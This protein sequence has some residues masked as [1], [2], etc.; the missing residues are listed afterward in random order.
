MRISYS[1]RRTGTV[2]VNVEPRLVG[3]C[4]AKP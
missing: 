1:S 4:S 2:N 3:S